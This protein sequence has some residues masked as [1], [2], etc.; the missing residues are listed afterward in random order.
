MQHNQENNGKDLSDLELMEK[1]RDPVSKEK[2]FTLLLRKYQ[3]KIYWAIRRVVIN[4][5]DA[6]D[7]IQNVF[8][9]VWNGLDTFRGESN[10]YTWIYRIAVNESITFIRKK[11][12][13][14]FVPWDVVEYR[15]SKSL[16]DDNYFRGDEIQLKLQ[17]AILTL[18]EK[19][20]IVFNMRY[21]D[22]MPYE[23]MSKVLETSEGA[24]KASFHH[25]VKK[26][27]NYL[28]NG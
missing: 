1:I 11:K 12:N 22:E 14:F 7:V 16:A 26:V 6:D 28:K 20:R 25:A 4:H 3:Q 27:E 9:N 5:D 10:L 15:L 23:E 24:L 13:R 2:G 21:Y 17:K 18:P 8:I 19:Q